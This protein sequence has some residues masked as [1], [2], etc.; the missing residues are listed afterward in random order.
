MHRVGDRVRCVS[1]PT[2]PWYGRVLA[3]ECLTCGESLTRGKCPKGHRIG[4]MTFYDGKVGWTY[5]LTIAQDNVPD[6]MRPW[7][8]PEHF[9]VYVEGKTAWERLLANRLVP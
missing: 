3:V 7:C 1:C 5:C 4:P 8:I 2:G 9:P 6:D